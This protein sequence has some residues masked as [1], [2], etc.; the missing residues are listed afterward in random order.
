MRYLHLRIWHAVKRRAFDLAPPSATVLVMRRVMLT[1]AHE[2]LPYSFDGGHAVTPGPS[3]GETGVGFDCSGVI[4]YVLW[5]AGLLKAQPNVNT[6]TLPQHLA[7]GEGTYITIWIRN[8]PGVHHAVIETRHLGLPR[9]FEAGHTGMIVGF[10]SNF[11]T[12]GYTAYR[13]P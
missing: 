6:E 5:R 9:F 7:R 13:R 12:A 4:R 1:V 2:R 11:D 8:S 3:R 10:I